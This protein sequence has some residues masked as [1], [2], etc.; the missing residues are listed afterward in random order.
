MLVAGDTFRAGATE[1]I[2]EWGKRVGVSVI[3]K[4]DSDPGSVIYN[5]LT[6]AKEENYDVVLVDTAGRLQNKVNIQ[7]LAK[8]NK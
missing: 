5:A 7:E 4:K 1:Q 6:I 3:G 2:E 8:I